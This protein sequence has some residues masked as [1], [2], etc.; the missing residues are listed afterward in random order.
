M[1]SR[2][3]RIVLVLTGAALLAGAATAI[4]PPGY[5]LIQVTRNDYFELQPRMN[6]HGQ[7]VFFK[8][9]GTFGEDERDDIMFYDGEQLINITSDTRHPRRDAFPDINDAGTIVWSRAIGPQGEWGRTFEIMMYR[10]GEMIRLTDDD[11]DDYAPRI[12]NNGHIVWSRDDNLGCLETSHTLMYYDGFEIHELTGDLYSNQPT[13][14]ND[15]NQIVWTRYDY[16]DY[17]DWDSDVLLWDNGVITTLDSLEEFEPQMP[18]INNLGVI[19]WQT[20]NRDT[21]VNSIRLWRDGV[22]TVF[23]D[24]GWNPR[25]NDLGDIYFLRWHDDVQLWQSWAYLE[26]QL[27]QL[28]NDYFWNTD[29]D[30]NNARQIVWCSGDVPWADIRL[31]D[32]D[33]RKQKNGKRGIKDSTLGRRSLLNLFPDREDLPARLHSRKE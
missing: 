29:G 19:A 1:K 23:T 26:G 28:T 22:T 5:R 8:R 13:E 24:W 6:N 33:S 25:L 21:G 9:I 4:V 7:F 14:I 15:R 11:K 20:R 18:A 27:F 12:N 32:P 10:D 30:I 17:P 31:L 16:C 3:R 2:I